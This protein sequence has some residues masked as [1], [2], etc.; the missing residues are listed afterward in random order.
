ML[1]GHLPEFSSLRFLSATGKL[2]CHR[3]LTPGSQPHN[4]LRK[5]QSSDYGLNSLNCELNQLILPLILFL[6]GI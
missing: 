4:W 6:F 5:T 3:I 1:S 2:G